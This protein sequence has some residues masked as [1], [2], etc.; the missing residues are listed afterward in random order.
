MLDIY[1][2]NDDGTYNIDGKEIIS[3]IE[4]AFYDIRLT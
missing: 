4:E 3:D 1:F 2:Y